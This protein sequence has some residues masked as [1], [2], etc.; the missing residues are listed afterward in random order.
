LRHQFE[1][2]LDRKL[3]NARPLYRESWGV[4]SGYVMG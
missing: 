1:R 3:V 4:R 2:R